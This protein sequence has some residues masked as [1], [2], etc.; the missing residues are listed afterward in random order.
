MPSGDQVGLV[1]SLACPVVTAPGV[2]FVCPVPSAFM[3]QTLSWPSDALTK[4]IRVP[5]GDHA[6]SV[7]SAG[8][9]V[10]FTSSL[11]SGFIE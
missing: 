8:S 5:S 1:P 7:S 10:R 9:L 2:R 11:P 6:G 4:A 3:T